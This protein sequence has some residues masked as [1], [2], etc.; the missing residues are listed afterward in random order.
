M[1]IPLLNQVQQ[2]LID[3]A[4]SKGLSLADDFSNPEEF[5]RFVIGVAFKGLMDAGATAEEAYDAVIGAS[6]YAVLANGDKLTT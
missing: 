5:K 4:N 3:H 2:M 1:N 6:N